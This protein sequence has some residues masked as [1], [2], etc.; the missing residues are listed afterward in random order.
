LNFLIFSSA[1]PRLKIENLKAKTMPFGV[2]ILGAG[3]SSRMGRPKLLL[4]WG[5]TSIIGHL[6]G[7]WRVLEAAQIAIVCRP[8]DRELHGELDR[9]DFSPQ[10]RVGNSEPERGMFSSILCAANWDGWKDNLTTWAIV[11]GDQPHLRLDTLQMLMAFHAK[12]PEA[13]CQPVYDGH[14][15]HPVFL[16]RWAFG[17]LKNS[18]D[19]D[20]NLFLKRNA[21]QLVKCTIKDSGL[22][23]DLDRPEDYEV[24]IKSHAGNL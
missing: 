21:C 2:V 13:I 16:P 23:L 14:A 8:D 3:A 11:L 19:N 22:A 18:R 5:K 7:Q 24:A 4:P 10:N 15:R 6:I 17:Q 1:M 20:L 9:L 12:H